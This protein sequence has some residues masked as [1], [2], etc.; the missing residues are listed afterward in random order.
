M[1]IDAVLRHYGGGYFR[2]NSTSADAD[3]GGYTI[4]PT[5][6]AGAGRWK[7]EAIA[8]FSARTVSPL[9]FGAKM[10]D[11][12]F[13]SAPAINA[14]ISYLNPYV[15]KDYDQVTGG[16]VVIP[17]GKYYINDTI[18]GAPNV[19]FIGTGGVPGFRQTMN[20]ATSIYAMTSMDLTKIMYDTAPWLTDNSARYKNR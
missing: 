20:G 7:R 13:D 10:N 16:D 9:E 15:N 19:R 11:S 18:Y 12:T 14:A 6:N 17:A 1:M 8:A 4:N 3:D 2:W 5:G